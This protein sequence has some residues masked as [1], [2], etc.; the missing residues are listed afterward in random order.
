MPFLRWIWNRFTEFVCENIPVEII[1]YDGKWDTLVWLPW[2]IYNNPPGAYS[3]SQ[4]LDIRGISN[5]V[6]TVYIDIFNGPVEGTVFIDFG[7]ALAPIWYPV[8]ENPNFSQSFYISPNDSGVIS[9]SFLLNIWSYSWIT[10]IEI[11]NLTTG[12]IMLQLECET[13]AKPWN[14]DW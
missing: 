3:V 6:C 7:V 9:F 11:R 10:P 13:T 5:I 4:W 8:N 12:D 2:A 1:N 14:P